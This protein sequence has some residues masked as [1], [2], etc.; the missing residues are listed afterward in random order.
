MVSVSLLHCVSTR[1]HDFFRKNHLRVCG[2]SKIYFDCINIPAACKGNPLYEADYVLSTYFNQLKAEKPGI[3]PLEGCSFNGTALYAPATYSYEAGSSMN[4]GCVVSSDPDDTPLTNEG[5]EAVKADG[6]PFSTRLFI[7]RVM[8]HSLDNAS[9]CKQHQYDKFSE[10]PSASF[11]ELKRD[12]RSAWWVCG[13]STLRDCSYCRPVGS[14]SF[15]YSTPY[16]AVASTVLGAVL[17]VA[18]GTC[19]FAR[20]KSDESE[21]WLKRSKERGGYTKKITRAPLVAQQFAGTPV[22]SARLV[23]QPISD[24]VRMMVPMS[25]RMVPAPVSARYIP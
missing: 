1:R 14:S 9:V 10:A 24:S 21:D 16:V 13:G 3:D 19:V 4:L 8:F 5:Y 12:L 11:Y 25:S 7:D 17:L 20:N 6:D 22:Q 15:V 2:D 18:I 23:Q